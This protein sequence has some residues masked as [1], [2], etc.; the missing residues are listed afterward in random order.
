MFKRLTDSMSQAQGDEGDD[1]TSLKIL[2]IFTAEHPESKLYLHE[3][4]ILKKVVR[5]TRANIAIAC[6]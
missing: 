3:T 4:T 6:A 2:P 1:P 5:E